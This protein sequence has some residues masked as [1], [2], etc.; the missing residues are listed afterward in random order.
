MPGKGNARKIFPIYILD[1]PN[2]RS[3][4]KLLNC[5]ISW[6]V[7][8]KWHCSWSLPELCITSS[9]W[10]ELEPLI[11]CSWCSKTAKSPLIPSKLG[12]TATSEN[13]LSYSTST[14]L[15]PRQKD[16]LDGNFLPNP[17]VVGEEGARGRCLWEGKFCVFPSRSCVFP[18]R[19]GLRATESK[20]C[21][22][23]VTAVGTCCC[24]LG[25]SLCVSNS[26]GIKRL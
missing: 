26:L 6:A 19:T 20:N 10:A 7:P 22:C 17:H 13:F 8:K 3:E 25:I 5:W 9:V 4:A 11:G 14:F 21:I 23:L 15:N 12:F 2:P 16:G 1:H 24:G 18:C